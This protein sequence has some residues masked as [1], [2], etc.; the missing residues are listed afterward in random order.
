MKFVKILLFVGAFTLLGLSLAAERSER[1]QARYQE[2][3]NSLR[4]ETGYKELL[5]PPDHEFNEKVLERNYGGIIYYKTKKAESTTLQTTMIK[6]GAFRSGI[7]LSNPDNGVFSS[8]GFSQIFINANDQGTVSYVPFVQLTQGCGIDVGNLPFKMT[9]PIRTVNGSGV[10][11][12]QFEDNTQDLDASTVVNQI[13]KLKVFRESEINR[14]VV[15]VLDAINRLQ[16]K[17]QELKDAKV[18]NVQ[19]VKAQQVKQKLINDL[20]RLQDEIDGRLDTENTKYVGLTT[21]VDLSHKKISEILQKISQAKSQIS[22]I[23][24][25]VLNLQTNITPESQIKQME[26]DLAKYLQLAKYWI[27]GAIFHRIID[28]NE[29]KP[30]EDLVVATNL[31]SFNT[32]VDDYFYPQ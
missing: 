1:S 26:A 12:F 19:A 10:F 18:K 20:G 21:K 5:T 16:A 30:L 4:V 9:C 15:G 11:T 24:S 31:V 29:A 32:K 7:P 28:E 13:N 8:A 22:S 23:R 17:T 2:M 14:A 25:I 3:T 6:E 27:Q